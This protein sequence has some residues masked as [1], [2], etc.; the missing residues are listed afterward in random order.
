MNK[1]YKTIDDDN[2]QYYFDNPDAFKKFALFHML[3]GLT[4]KKDI[5][6]SMS[7][8]KDVEPDELAK[9]KDGNSFYE[10]FEAESLPEG[11]DTNTLNPSI[12]SLYGI[13]NNPNYLLSTLLSHPDITGNIT[14]NMSTD[15]MLQFIADTYDEGIPDDND[16]WDDF[17]N[18]S[19]FIP[20]ANALMKYFPDEHASMLNIGDGNAE[21]DDVNTDG[22]DD[23]ATYD[24]NGNGKQDTAVVKGDD[25]DETAAGVEHAI[26]K[27]E[28]ENDSGKGN[29]LSTGD[30]I[31]S[32]AS[33]KHILSA[34]LERRF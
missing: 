18:N 25:P 12:S 16:T 30:S 32:D 8:Y 2:T 31:V 23:V 14:D 7:L 26:N 4:D 3:S 28:K 22:D 5:L 9:G 20:H 24:T 34:L 17:I 21:L 1:Y 15:D 27:L 13:E 19:T 11:V 29:K 10:V 6:D 33:K